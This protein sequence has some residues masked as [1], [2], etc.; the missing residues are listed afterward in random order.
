MRRSKRNRRFAKSKN[1]K[2][3][4]KLEKFYNLLTGGDRIDVRFTRRKNKIL[5][6][7]VTYSAYI[8]KRWKAVVRFDTAH[9]DIYY[10]HE[11]VFYHKKLPRILNYNT[12]DYNKF[13]TQAY[14]YI[15]NNYKKLRERYFLSKQSYDP[16][17]N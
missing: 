12:S 14:K 16:K 8:D 11:H 10:P 13:L 1:G 6:V 9:D 5:K 7:S 4:I 17:N 2:Y 3:G 15:V